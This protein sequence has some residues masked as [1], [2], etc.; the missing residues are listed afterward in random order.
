MNK[1]QLI[2][3]LRDLSAKMQ[4]LGSSMEYYYGLNEIGEKGREL[5]G[6]GLIANQWADQIESENN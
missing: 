5:L 6:A 4:S 1:D 3:E 2:I